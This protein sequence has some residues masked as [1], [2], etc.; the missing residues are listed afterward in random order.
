MSIPVTQLLPIGSII[1]LKGAERNLMIYGVMQTQDDPEDPREFDYVGVIYPEGHIGQQMQF[2][3]DHQD[4]EEI[5]FRGYEDE[6]R[7]A[8]LEKLQSF[9]VQKDEDGEASES[10]EAE[11]V[12]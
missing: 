3:F 5:V 6:E 11:T 9:Y 1:R 8:F 4:I 12:E 10:A 7:T 2:L